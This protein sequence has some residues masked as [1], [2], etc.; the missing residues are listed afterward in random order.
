VLRRVLEIPGRVSRV[1]IVRA[2]ELVANPRVAE[3]GNEDAV[4]AGPRDECGEE[5]VCTR[6]DER[7]RAASERVPDDDV[8]RWN[9]GC[10]LL[11]PGSDVLAREI[12]RMYDMPARLEL[13]AHEVPAPATVPGPVDKREGRHA[14]ILPCA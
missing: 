6:L 10:V 5:D 9:A 3:A 4:P 14:T 7:D 2:P 8:R 11:N 12:R 13:R 1:R